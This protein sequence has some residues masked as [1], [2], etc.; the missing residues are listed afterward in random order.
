MPAIYRADLIVPVT[1]KSIP[2]G[3]I[4]VADD[5]TIISLHDSPAPAE[6]IALKGILIPGFVNTHCHLELSHLRGRLAEKTGMTGF[7]RELL[8]KRFSVSPEAQLEA[9]QAAE[10][11]MLEN[12]IVAVGDISNFEHSLAVKGKSNLYYHTFVEVLG[13]NPEQ[14]NAVMEKGK[15]LQQQFSGIQQH[16]STIV[17]HAPYSLSDELFEKI[18]SVPTA[19]RNPSTIHMEESEDENI[20]CRTA[21]GPIAAF[22]K[23]FGIDFSTFIPTPEKSPLL[24]TLPKLGLN[25]RT[26]FV[27]N[28]LLNVEEALIAEQYLGDVYWCLCPNANLYITNK[29]PDFSI[30]NHAQRK[31]TIGTDSL[32]SNHGLSILE[33]LKTISASAP[34]VSFETLIRWSTYNG[35]EF[36]GIENRFGH[37][38][39][40]T[41]PGLVLLENCNVENPTFQKNISL[42]RIL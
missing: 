41:K 32:A 30:F 37:F 6:A 24:R 33:A 12:G 17:P 11:E 23:D 7:I 8:A 36:L 25:G 26:L 3:W 2:N 1:G 38:S 20:F 13:L 4:E 10:T 27:H 22:Y 28:T 42:R 14:A 16:S 21:A 39:P 18:K 34:A 9:M 15:I 5:G 40:G 35:A 31:V 19:E 29:L